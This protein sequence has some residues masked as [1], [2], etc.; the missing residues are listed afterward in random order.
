[1]VRW[2][3]WLRWEL[4]LSLRRCWG[5]GQLKVKI[6]FEEV[7]LPDPERGVAGKYRLKSLPD[8][9][10]PHC[11]AHWNGQFNF[12]TLCIQCLFLGST[13]WIKLQLGWDSPSCQPLAGILIHVK[14]QSLAE[15]NSV[16]GHLGLIRCQVSGC[17]FYQQYKWSTSVWQG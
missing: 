16:L 15:S 14:C 4:R 12:R 1:M 10:L 13:R 5:L 17:C 9:I 11:R 6:K 2:F 3:Y 8:L 7:G